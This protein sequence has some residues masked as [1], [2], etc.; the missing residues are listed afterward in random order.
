M[1]IRDLIRI[2][3][4]NQ[5]FL[6]DIKNYKEHLSRVNYL[7]E[8][9]ELFEF[10]RLQVDKGYTLDDSLLNYDKSIIAKYKPKLDNTRKAY[11]EW[12]DK[13]ITWENTNV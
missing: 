2:I 3:N 5:A 11:E 8:N 1:K 7:N 9:C 13:E 10:V 4:T 12:L 6:E